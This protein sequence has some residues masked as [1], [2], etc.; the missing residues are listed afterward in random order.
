MGPQSKPLGR[1]VAVARENPCGE[2]SGSGW[3]LC[4]SD[5]SLGSEG[6]GPLESPEHCNLRLCPCSGRRAPRQRNLL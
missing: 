4:V 2:I 5:L 6:S 1:R 3:V